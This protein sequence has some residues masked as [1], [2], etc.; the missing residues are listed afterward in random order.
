MKKLLGLAFLFVGLI[1]FN[2]QAQDEAAEEITDE[3]IAKFAAMEDSV[4]AFYE[5]KNAELVSMIK[6]N[7]VIDGA[8][9]YNE[10]KGAWDDEAKLTEIEITDEEKV[11]YEAIL[12]FMGSLSTE[13]RE[14]KIGLIKNDDVLGISTFNKVNKAMKA[15]PE[16]KEKVDSEIAQL[17]EKRSTEEEESPSDAG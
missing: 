3:E 6:D 2:A 13:V 16:I 4:M 11:A 1:G 12:E 15:N 8:A 10:I 7:E 17:K 9:R 5:Q 14:M